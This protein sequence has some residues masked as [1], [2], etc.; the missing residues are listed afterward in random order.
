MKS[1]IFTLQQCEDNAENPGPLTVSVLYIKGPIL[2]RLL[3]IC[4]LAKG[5][6]K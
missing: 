6:A 4:I 5:N 3:P 2:S 1:G